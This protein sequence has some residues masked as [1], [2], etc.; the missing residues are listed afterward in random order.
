MNGKVQP[1]LLMK[2]ITRLRAEAK[3]EENRRK[4]DFEENRW[5]TSWLGN[6]FNGLGTW[7]KWVFVPAIIIA[8]VYDSLTND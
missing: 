3:R 7:Y 2:D 6:T 5:N 4:K 1:D 8:F